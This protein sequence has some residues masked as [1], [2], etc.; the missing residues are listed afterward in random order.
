MKKQT[1]LTL[2]LAIWTWTWVG[3]LAIATFGPK[4]IW[5]EHQLLTISG[6]VIN[7]IIGI[8]MIIANRNLFNNLDEL[9]RKI[10]LEALGITLG[11]TVVAGISYSLLDITNLISDNAEIGLLVGFIGMCYL[12]AVLI[13]RKR[14]L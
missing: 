5:G 14:Y 13:N 11:L 6:V 12:S 8:A 1:K 9:Q 10:Q 3:S 4:F 7:F 2:K